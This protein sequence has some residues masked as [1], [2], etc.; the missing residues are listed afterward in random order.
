MIRDINFTGRHSLDNCYRI[1]ARKGPAYEPFWSVDVDLVAEELQKFDLPDSFVCW[2][3]IYYGS[4]Q[5]R[6]R[7]GDGDK[8]NKWT[9]SFKTSMSNEIYFKMRLKIVASDDPEQ[10]ILASKRTIIPETVDMN[11]NRE[12]L[13]PV[14]YDDTLGSIPWTLKLDKEENVARPVLYVNC[15]LH[16]NNDDTAED[17]VKREP[18]FAALVLPEAMRQILTAKL[19]NDENEEVDPDDPWIKF[20]SSTAKADVINS[21]DKDGRL[22]IIE[23]AVESFCANH[24]LLDIE[25]E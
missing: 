19:C 2:V 1:V 12:P 20:I 7:M 11:G 9:D 4:R 13:L 24:H 8:K 25:R 17:I 22:E 5:Q 18:L 10:K 23:A 3:E 15:D 14:K 21:K 16:R 6:F